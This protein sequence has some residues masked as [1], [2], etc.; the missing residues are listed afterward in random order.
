[1]IKAQTNHPT[2]TGG[3]TMYAKII[4]AIN[5]ANDHICNGQDAEEA[6]NDAANI[7]A[8]NYD[9]YLAI[10]RAFEEIAKTRK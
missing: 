5:Y 1:M 10:W 6:C 3:K 7:Y 4:R 8:A 9:E 2:N